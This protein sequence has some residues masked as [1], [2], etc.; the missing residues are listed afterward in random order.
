LLLLTAGQRARFA[1]INYDEP[2]APRTHA[3]QAHVPV[4][5]IQTDLKL[6]S[7]GFFDT[8][9]NQSRAMSEALR[10][11]GKPQALVLTHS[12][13]EAYQREVLAALDAFLGKVDPVAP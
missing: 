7:I 13:D 8:D 4:L 2:F 11:A 1:D 6:D 3:S 9:A 5:L 10:K 12:I